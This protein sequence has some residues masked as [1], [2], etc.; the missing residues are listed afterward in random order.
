MRREAHAALMLLLGAMAIRLASSDAYLAYVKAPMRPWLLLSGA[1][2]VALAGGVLLHRDSSA[3][4]SGGPGH[5]HSPGVA[6]LLALPVL[7]LTVVAPDPLGAFAAGRAADWEPT[8]PAAAFG[9]LP[10]PTD[11]AVDLTLAEFRGRAAFDEHQSL[12]GA[13]VRLTGFVQETTSDGFILA[14]F[15]LRCCAA[16]AAPIR[17]AIR[18]GTRPAADSWVEV[19][20]MWRLGSP[21][22]D[23][24]HPAELD[25]AR[26]EGIEEPGQ[27][28]E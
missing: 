11:G 10:A 6:W 5:G 4:D 9:P 8:P 2:I 27:P 14:R 20:G 13:T 1:V 25:A 16:D 3:E 19:T 24:G 18:T 17:V 15:V 22:P 21:T 23:D 28:Y 26:V 7:A 12:K